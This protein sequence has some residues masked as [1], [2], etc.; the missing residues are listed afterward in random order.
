MANLSPVFGSKILIIGICSIFIA[1]SNVLANTQNHGIEVKG[2][3]S[4]LVEPDSFALSISIKEIGRLTDKIRTIV[5]HKSNQIIAVAQQLGIKDQ[6]INSARV[7]LQVVKDESVIDLY[8][9]EVNQ[10]LPNNQKSKVYLGVPKQENAKHISNTRPQYFELSRNI[11]INFSDI[12]DYDHFL[13]AIIKIGVSQISPL[14]MSVEDTDKYYQQALGQAIK[15]AKAKAVQIANQTEQSLGKL[16]YVK[17]IS[18]NHYRARY[19]AP[20]MSA[21]ASFEHSSQIGSQ[22]ISA[23]VLVNYSI[24]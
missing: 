22:Q 21:N 11:T 6:Q 23:S 12:K 10:R 7:S 1:P 16:V 5:D 20:M 18:S 19:N 15:N 14:T 17:E 24:E 4:V 3:A 8:G 2:Q 13:N 9:L